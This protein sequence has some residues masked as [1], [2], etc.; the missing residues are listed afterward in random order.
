MSLK[1][2][3]LFALGIAAGT[4]AGFVVGSIIAL[5]VGEQGVDAVRR[6]ADRVLG[7]RPGPKFEYLLQ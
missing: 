2:D 4:A 5:R 7:R 1:R 3:L 6:V